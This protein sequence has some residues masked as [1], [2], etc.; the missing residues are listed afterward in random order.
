M[1]SNELTPAL[2]ARRRHQLNEAANRLQA[3]GMKV[4]YTNLSMLTGLSN[5]QISQAFERDWKNKR[6]NSSR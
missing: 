3:Q 2:L 1:T 4:T 5:R 6:N